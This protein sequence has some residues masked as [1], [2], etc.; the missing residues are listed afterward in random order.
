M[1][2]HKQK[3][4]KEPGVVLVVLAVLAVLDLP[5]LWFSAYSAPVKAVTAQESLE[6]AFPGLGVS[7]SGPVVSC[8]WA[9]KSLIKS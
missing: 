4:L 6:D 5:H 2:P 3:S 8:R 7:H 1:C 9:R